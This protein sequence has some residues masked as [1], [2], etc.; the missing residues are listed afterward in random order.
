MRSRSIF[1]IRIILLFFTVI[2]AV[3]ANGQNKNAFKL[4]GRINDSLSNISLP[5]A[6]LILK[7]ENTG[8][9]L[10]TTSN[11]S[12]NFSF[13]A[14]D[15][16]SYFL[17]VKY[18]G[19]KEYTSSR[20]Q[21]LNAD[22]T[23]PLIK[24]STT[25]KALK[26]VDIT[27]R[28]PLI[29][30]SLDKVTMNISES[31]IFAGGTALDILQQA[32]GVQITQ[33]GGISLKSKA[34]SV[35]IDGRPSYLSG[36][37]LK[38]WLSSQPSNAID[39]VELISNPSA[40]YDASSSAII[41]IKTTKMLNYG[42]NGNLTLNAG[43]GKFDRENAGVNLNY[44]QQKINIYGSYNYMSL[45]QY[46]SLINNRTVQ[47]GNQGIFLNEDQYA[48]KRTNVNAVKAGVDYDINTSNTIGLLLRGNFTSRNHH[49]D[50]Q[51][52]IGLAGR[53]PD[54]VVTTNTKG[55]AS[56]SSP[57]VNIFYKLNDVKTK[58]TLTINGDYY[59]YGKKSGNDYLTSY[60]DDAGQVL[61]DG[62]ELR[63]NSPGHI[64]IRSIAA[65]YEKTI[66]AGKLSAGVKTAFTTTDNDVKWEN[67]LNDTWVTD[68]TKTNHFIYDENI[69]AAYI[70]FTRQMKKVGVQVMLRG[71]ETNVT[72]NSLTLNTEFKKNYFQLFPSVAFQYTKSAQ[73]QF[74]FAYRK[75]IERPLYQYVN[76][77]LI[78]QSTYNYFQGNPNLDPM[79]KHEFELSWAHK[80]TV[81]TSLSYNYIKNFYGTFYKQN[82]ETKGIISYFDNYKYGQSVNLNIAVSKLL[83]SWWGL[84]GNFAASY[85]KGSYN[86]V[87]SGNSTISTA[88]TVTNGFILKHGWNADLVLMY[89]TPY[90]DGF[91][92]YKQNFLMNTGLSKTLNRNSSLKLSGSDIFR[93]YRVSYKTE[94]NNINLQNI[95]RYDTRAVTLTYSYKFGNMRVKKQADRKGGIDKEEK[96]VG[97]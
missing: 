83:E 18:V 29:T 7:K 70:G 66:K 6:G 81:F 62:N 69:N 87:A 56:W 21:I 14:L 42:M 27:S 36:D 40:K 28:K 64:S 39:K 43:A 92:H 44:R 63:D 93:T 53:Q 77:F 10:T 4:S 95:A 82:D 1:I 19:Y 51:T 94:Y 49:D 65:D 86:T 60:T 58:Q 15:T 37:E 12:G 22:I 61:H 72:G 71:E 59:R 91:Y 76:P 3:K 2:I 54:S 68:L 34:V 74:S 90:S 88:F 30:Q 9:S 17:T 32:P 47:S 20:I 96:R 13:A 25:L 41:N 35:Y 8:A 67:L 97:Q 78:F 38:S 16:G 26:T 45:K 50:S 89:T 73:N 24:L 80:Q 55:H 33:S 11:S 79:T 52:P 46:S 75:S 5:N 31:T 57:S 85:F 84:N 23:L 48:V